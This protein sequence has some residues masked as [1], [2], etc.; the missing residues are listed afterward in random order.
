MHLLIKFPSRLRPEKFESTLDKYISLSEHPEKIQYL[1]TL[2]LDDPAINEY[3]DIQ[4]RYNK[5]NITWDYGISSSKVSACNRGM[6]KT[7]DWDIVVLASD[8]MIP[9]V[10]GWDSFISEAM[11][12]NFP[13]TDGVIHF[14]DGFQ[15]DNIATLSIIGRKNYHLRGYIYHPLYLG[16][17]CD[18]EHT[19]V[20]ILERKY[21]Y[22]GDGNVIIKHIHRSTVHGIASDELYERWDN[23]KVNTHDKMI[24]DERRKNGYDLKLEVF[25]FKKE[26]NNV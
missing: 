6:S 25:N 10:K 9:Q 26:Y 20:S 5:V 13:D 17:W 1:I 11:K 8:D 2:D 22:M 3:R 24:F 21:K 23:P 18:V 14:D 7:K 4:R 19:E 12:Y 15:K 16:L